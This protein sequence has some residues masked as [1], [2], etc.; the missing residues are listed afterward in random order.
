MQHLHAHRRMPYIEAPQASNGSREDLFEQLARSDD[1]RAS[2][3]LR[4]T[5]HSFLV[6]NKFPYNAGHLL[7]VPNRKVAQLVELNAAERVDFFDSIVEGQ[8]IL[9]RALSPDGF[10]VGFNLGKAAGAGIPQ[11]LHCHIVPR[12]EG[13]TNF[14]PVVSNTRVLPEAM[15]AMWERLRTFVDEFSANGS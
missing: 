14:M 12:W 10:N 3:I 9:E 11:H 6:M 8:A 15:E 2:L 1:D 5:E 4:R 13:D 7:A